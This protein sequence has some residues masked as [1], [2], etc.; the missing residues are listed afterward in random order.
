MQIKKPKAQGTALYTVDGGL[1]LCLDLNISTAAEEM[2]HKPGRHV[3]LQPK[4]VCHVLFLW[5]YRH[6]HQSQILSQDTFFFFLSDVFR[7][8]VW[9]DMAFYIMGKTDAKLP[10]FPPPCMKQF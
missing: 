10:F 3:H 8:N 5:G 9:F 2:N 7:E 6:F 4:E 1:C